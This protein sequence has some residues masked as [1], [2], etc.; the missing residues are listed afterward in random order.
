MVWFLE[1]SLLVEQLWT[2]ET[3]QWGY[4]SNIGS[5]LE[6]LQTGLSKVKLSKVKLSK[7]NTKVFPNKKAQTQTGEKHR[8]AAKLW[9]LRLFT[10]KL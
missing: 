3:E 5:C 7:V 6:Y 9:A 2:S 4:T 10:G 1:Q 8:G